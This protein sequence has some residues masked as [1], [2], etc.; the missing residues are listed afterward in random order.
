MP[1]GD[2]LR[3]FLILKIFAYRLPR[4]RPQLSRRI[5][6]QFPDEHT[7]SS[8]SLPLRLHVTVFRVARSCNPTGFLT[9]CNPGPPRELSSSFPLVSS[10][11]G[12][13]LSLPV[14]V[15]QIPKYR[16]PSCKAREG[17]RIAL[18]FNTQA[19]IRLHSIRFV[20][21]QLTFQ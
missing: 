14:L 13:L 21:R 10:S 2:G 19:A 8:H 18:P 4:P 15:Q 9:R 17:Q 20:G 16:Y 5:W 11:V 6:P 1:F 3:H 7:R 12:R